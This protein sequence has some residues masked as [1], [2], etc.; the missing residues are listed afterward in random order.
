[1]RGFCGRKIAPG[2]GGGGLR[3]S[4]PA[5]RG[6]GLL[7]RG[8]FCQGPGFWLFPGKNNLKRTFH[9]KGGG[10]AND[11]FSDSPQRADTR[12]AVFM[13]FGFLVPDRSHPISRSGNGLT[14]GPN[15]WG[16]GGGLKTG[17]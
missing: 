1:M 2:G 6:R 5:P 14:G 3:E 8:L 16:V 7:N 12:N 15:P 9:Q 17:L 13:V 10:G 4:P 11:D